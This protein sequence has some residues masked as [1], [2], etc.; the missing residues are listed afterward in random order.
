MTLN[1]IIELKS[2]IVKTIAEILNESFPKG[3]DLKKFV[4]LPLEE[5]LLY[6][7]KTIPKS[8]LDEGS[9][10]IVYILDSKRVLKIAKNKEEGI[11]QNRNE[12]KLS[13]LSQLFLEITPKIYSS[14][15][16][17]EWLISELVK[18]LINEKEFM[19]ITQFSWPLFASVLF[20]SKRKGSINNAIDSLP[21]SS[22]G[23]GYPENTSLKN[24]ALKM[25]KTPLFM[26]IIKAIDK[27]LNVEDI[28][29]LGQWGKTTDNKIVLLD[30]GYVN[31]D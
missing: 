25:I 13:Q 10:R 28:L 17:D 23:Y 1:N 9:S 11:I 15:P 30:A 19:S 6:A 12:K 5:K 7:Q 8:F 20:N 24:E 22:K 16:D 29:S 31:H 2:F 14:S 26:G 4:D 27:G 21:T 3:F 18:P